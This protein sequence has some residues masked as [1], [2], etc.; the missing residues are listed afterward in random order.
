MSAPLTE[1][2]RTHARVLHRQL[3]QVGS[4]VESE[5]DI[6]DA[7]V[8][9]L[10]LRVDDLT[11]NPGEAARS[12]GLDKLD[13][14]R[15]LPSIRTVTNYRAYVGE[16]IRQGRPTIEEAPPNA[17]AHPSPPRSLTDDE[18]LVTSEPAMTVIDQV[19]ISGE[20]GWTTAPSDVAQSSQLTGVGHP[21]RWKDKVPL[22]RWQQRAGA[23]WAEHGRRGIFQVV[24]GAGKT[25]FALYQL[26]RL[27]EEKEQ[28]C[29]GLFAVVIVPR[30]ALIDQWEENIRTHLDV[31]GLA[32]GQYYGRRKCFLPAQDILLITAQSARKVL[33]EMLF[34]RDTLLIADECHGL[35]A[36][37]ASR[38]F[39]APFT[40][41]LG[42]SATP[43]RGG[44]LGFEDILVPN[45][46]PIVFKYGFREAIAD[47]IISEFEVV[48]IGLPLSETERAEYDERSESIK[49]LINS[50]KANY[51]ELRRDDGRFHQTRGWL[52]KQH[53]WDD[54][55]DKLTAALAARSKVLHFAESKFAAVSQ[56]ARSLPRNRRVLCFH[57]R[58]DAAERLA[59]A[60]G[61]EGQSYEVYH[62]KIHQDERAERLERFARSESQWMVTCR[63]LDE[64][65]DIPSVDTII[66]AAG[67]KSPRQ[68]IQRLG[69]ALRKIPGGKRALVI[70][71]ET[72]EVED[73]A[74]TQSALQDLREAASGLRDFSLG[75]FLHEFRGPATP[76]GGPLEAASLPKKLVRKAKKLF[77]GG[78]EKPSP[79]KH[80]YRGAQDSAW[81]GTTGMRS[82]YDK[83]SSPD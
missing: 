8:E 75:R 1:P 3:T 53:P 38:V 82:Y 31:S 42:L 18:T 59:E 64:G 37:A 54:R 60:I 58:I 52:A 5:T 7:A 20:M 50:L 21:R 63:S 51:P 77:T 43:E 57:E 68:T 72:P 14:L 25:V 56:L 45:L 61:S 76:K 55:F 10:A 47:G 34:D 30:I 27:L 39:D 48:R 29:E 65:I 40:W 66:I 73:G 67:T 74:I 46:G 78:V 24:T 4:F 33:P 2:A 17:L 23:V 44:D 79:V 41:T 36:P 15:V 35:G 26:A 71:L 49:K 81:I 32:V 22:H 70:I 13:L 16:W 19:D 28:R 80:R 83:A 9:Y 11:G 12:R 6:T 69:R 62:S